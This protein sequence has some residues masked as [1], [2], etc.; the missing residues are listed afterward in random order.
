MR[1]NED[2]NDYD[3]KPFV[4]TIIDSEQSFHILGRAGTG[5]STLTKQIQEKLKEDN[6]IYIT[7]C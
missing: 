2:V 4:V 7:L 6:K 5:K 3:F 1:T